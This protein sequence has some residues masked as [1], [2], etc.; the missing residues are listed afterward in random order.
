MLYFRI[1][2]VH[3]FH[4]PAMM[5]TPENTDGIPRSRL[6]LEVTPT[7]TSSGQNLHG[8]PGNNLHFNSQQ[9]HTPNSRPQHVQLLNLQSPHFAHLSPHGGFGGGLRGTPRVNSKGQHQVTPGSGGSSGG[10]YEASRTPR[11][12]Q[13]RTPKGDMY[14]NPFELDPDVM[15]GCMFSPGVFSAN[16]GTQSSQKV[17]YFIVNWVRLLKFCGLCSERNYKHMPSQVI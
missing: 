15:E 9:Y 1:L 13:F 10:R 5:L 17:C 4:E 12:S 11:G 14:Y 6:R 16:T 7:Q 3:V 2:F 8:T